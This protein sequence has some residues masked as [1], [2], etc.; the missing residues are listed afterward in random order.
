MD[1]RV[2]NAIKRIA[3]ISMGAV[4]VGT[5]VMSAVHAAT[6]YTLA[7]FPAPFVAAGKGDFTIV[8][9]QDAKPDDIIGAVDVGV[10]LQASSGGV[11]GQAAGVI[12]G[13]T[14][15]IEEPGNP[16]NFVDPA[17]AASETFNDVIG[18]GLDDSDLPTILADGHFKDSRGTTDNEEDYTQRI[19]F[20][21]NGEKLVYDADD[22]GSKVLGD[23]VR[24][25]N[26]GNFYTYTLEF[27]SAIDFVDN[28]A[29]AAD[30]MENTQIEIQGKPYIITKFAYEGT[31]VDTIDEIELLTGKTIVTLTQ[32]DSYT[33][34]GKSV[35]ITSVTEPDAPQQRCGVSIDG[36]TKF[37]D[38]GTDEEFDGFRVG[39]SDVFAIHGAVGEDA[40]EI[41]LGSVLTKLDNG[42]EVQ[43]NGEDIG[44][45]D[46]DPDVTTLATI[47]PTIGAEA[48]QLEGFEISVKSD[49][50][51]NLGS[52][53]D[54]K[55]WL[56]PVFGNFKIS[57][58]GLSGDVE[59]VAFDLSSDDGTFTYKNNEGKTVEIPMFS[60]EVANPGAPPPVNFYPT[61]YGEAYDASMLIE[62]TVGAQNMLGLFGG[63]CTP[64]NMVAGGFKDLTNGYFKIQDTVALAADGIDISDMSG[65]LLYLSTAGQTSRVVEIT[66]IKTAPDDTVTFKDITY[67]RSGME[68]KPNDGTV[69]TDGT[70]DTYKISGI[71]E[72]RLAF[73]DAF[74]AGMGA[75]ANC[76]APNDL[77][78]IQLVDGNLADAG[79]F[80]DDNDWNWFTGGYLTDG[81][82]VIVPEE[83]DGYGV[84]VDGTDAVW[85]YTLESN[86]INDVP[87]DEVD[88]LVYNVG[89]PDK[90]LLA[91]D[92]VSF[93][94]WATT[95]NFKD[96]SRTDD[97]NQYAMTWAGSKW[98]IALDENDNPKNVDADLAVGEARLGNAFVA[99]T[100]ALFTAPTTGTA[101]STTTTTA[102]TGAVARL[103]TEITDKT[104]T[105]M[106]LIGGPCV[107]RLTADALAQTYPACGTDVATAL[108]VPLDGAQIA[109]YN[110]AFNGT[111]VAMTVMGTD[112]AGTRAASEV[113]KRFA[114][115]KAQ[116]TGLKVNVKS[117]AGV[118]T[119][120][121]PT[122][123]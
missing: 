6:S 89:F 14:V 10:G 113:L 74:G 30:D 13:E 86:D 47:N 92:P 31:A 81:N 53:T 67:G 12:S 11:A 102:F 1:I 56:D 94:G 110:N 46:G 60:V 20:A 36:V 66:S 8:V 50:E 29:D 84:G 88:T 59:N 44:D 105:N 80:Q 15:K 117:T 122:V 24:V 104:A 48:G 64:A 98:H 16:L 4:M 35:I 65:T 73:W 112:A 79:D 51:V 90:E 41:T 82:N 42:G 23:Y 7:D 101:T 118:I 49:D 106:I 121:A 21:A 83:T 78:A 22:D 120:S 3:A 45:R 68:V 25:A 40:C 18:A 107:N 116:L 119:V 87:L 93:N 63:A 34:E 9:G 76:D 62:S 69:S 103:D 72:V 97:K 2:K 33:F 91:L 111:K 32:G 17:G 39:V 100:G 55:D 108:G 52:A 61:Y 115:F 77:A 54:G 123:A 57:Y 43:I 75:L 99:E 38:E 70:I 85:I 5:S 96:A 95:G 58:Q 114:E 19:D 109:L 26:N 37:I 71:G 27:T 28:T